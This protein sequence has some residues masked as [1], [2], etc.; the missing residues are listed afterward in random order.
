M[1]HVTISLSLHL[2][3]KDMANQKFWNEYS[4]DGTHERTQTHASLSLYIYYLRVYIHIYIYLNRKYYVIMINNVHR[5]KPHRKTCAQ[6]HL[7]SSTILH[8]PKFFLDWSTGHNKV[9]MT[10]SSHGSSST[11]YP[12]PQ[13]IQVA[14]PNSPVV[15]SEWP[16]G[17]PPYQSL[18][19]MHL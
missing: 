9:A 6:I 15:P 3:Q 10:W 8:T 12:H 14:S 18:D 2:H 13:P 7:K 19:H 5:L 11:N 4:N 16:I 1:W 17:Y